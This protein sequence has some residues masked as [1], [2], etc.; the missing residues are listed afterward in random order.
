MESN[1]INGKDFPQM[2]KTEKRKI[3]EDFF[4]NDQSYDDLGTACGYSFVDGNP[5]IGFA[6]V[7][8]FMEE[9]KIPINTAFKSPIED[10]FFIY[11]NGEESNLFTIYLMDR[12]VYAESC[13]ESEA[14]EI[15]EEFSIKYPH[16]VP[17]PAGYPPSNMLVDVFSKKNRNSTFLKAWDSR[18]L[19]KNNLRYHDYAMSLLNR[20]NFKKEVAE[21]DNGKLTENEFLPVAEA[22]IR[23]VPEVWIVHNRRTNEVVRDNELIFRDYK[24]D[25]DIDTETAKAFFSLYR[26]VNSHSQNEEPV[27]ILLGEGKTF[28]KAIISLARLVDE[29][30]D[31]YWDA[32]EV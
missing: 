24:L 20:F 10:R 15:I 1:L 30:Y 31:L 3:L 28:N 23:S 5:S 9:R 7:H 32:L 12:S 25:Y 4:N 6:F 27:K 8:Q 29:S 2:S 16:L 13:T 22:M 18:E 21:F 26:T 11:Y 17:T 14:R 19:S